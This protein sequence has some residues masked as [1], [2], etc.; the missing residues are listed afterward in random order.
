MISDPSPSLAR[1]R[2]CAALIKARSESGL[3]QGDVAATLEWSWSKVNRIEAGVVGVS[4]TDLR[5]MLGLYSITDAEE[6]ER[7]TTFARA[8]RGASWWSD[9]AGV[10]SK[11]A[12]KLLDYERQAVRINAFHPLLVPGLLQTPAYAQQMVA[13]QGSGA[14]NPKIAE[15]RIRRQEI[16]DWA[17]PPEAMFL[18]AEAVLHNRMCTRTAM[19]EQLQALADRA[20]SGPM[21]VG[22]IPF[23]RSLYPAMLIPFTLIELPGG[24]TVFFNEAPHGART[25]KNDQELDARYAEYFRR[26]HTEQAVFGAQAVHLIERALK[27]LDADADE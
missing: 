22:V 13:G 20:A 8:A 6:I 10:V 27:G 7:L 26:L 2:L 23:A 12:A 14:D 25:A 11:G 3:T 19:A 1:A 9:F 15:L 17:Q 5:A 4:I 18:I 21:T 16:W 24:E